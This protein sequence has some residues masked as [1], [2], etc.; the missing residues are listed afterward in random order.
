MRL[1]SGL[2]TVSVRELLHCSRPSRDFAHLLVEFRGSRYGIVPT[3]GPGVAAQQPSRREPGALDGPVDL[4]RPQ[5]VRRATRVVT[6]DVPVQRADHQPIGLQQSDQDVLH[7]VPTLVTARDQAETRS[8][9]SSAGTVAARGSA[10]TTTSTPDGVSGS[11][12]AARWRRRRLTRLRVTALPT[13]LETT[14]PTRTDGP[15]DRPACTTSV[16]RPARAPR[17]VVR[18]KSSELLIRAERGSTGGQNRSGRELGAALATARGEDRPAGTS[19]HPE[20]EAV[21]AAATPIARLERTLA[22]GKTP[23]YVEC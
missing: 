22:H 16:G 8:G 14:K 17:R 20:A 18:R 15:G 3:G 6:A 13:C 12:P 23:S 4:Y 7:R 21:G 2:P 11:S 10:R 9:A 5:R 1:G 19:P